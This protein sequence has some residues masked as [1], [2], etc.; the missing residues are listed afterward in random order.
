MITSYDFC[1]VDPG[2]KV[3]V[4]VTMHMHDSHSWD[5][6]QLG[7]SLGFRRSREILVLSP[8]AT[9]GTTAWQCLSHD[10]EVS[11]G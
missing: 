6:E 9:V 11:N 7:Q 5:L 8:I 1:C 10:Q 4:H 3:T 2:C